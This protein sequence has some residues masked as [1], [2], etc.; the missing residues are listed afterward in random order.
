MIGAHARL[1][2]EDA[3]ADR[4]ADSEQDKTRPCTKLRR[5][6]DKHA[7]Y[8]LWSDYFKGSPLKNLRTFDYQSILSKVKKK[9]L[10]IEKQ[11][12]PN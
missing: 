2:D 10:K 7:A 4:A 12:N 9:T 3:E 11:T 1:D 8:C 5:S 6:I